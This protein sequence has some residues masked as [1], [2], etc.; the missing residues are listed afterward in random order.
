MGIFIKVGMADY[1]IARAP[2]KLLTAGLGSCI[3]ICLCDTSSQVG[4]LAHIMLPSGEAARGKSHNHAK[5]ADTALEL[6]LHELYKNG[7]AP[8]RLI[9]KIAGG[10]Q[11]FKFLGENDIMKIGLR[12]A[13]AVEENLKKHKIRI[14]AKDVGGNVGRTIVFDPATGELLIKTLGNGE[15]II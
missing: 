12:N 6:V 8:H 14:A 9:A 15:R 3:G 7:I 5:F 1:K 2:D 11:M 13:Q 10:A 4:A